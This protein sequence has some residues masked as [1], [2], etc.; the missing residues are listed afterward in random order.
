MI[1][2]FVRHWIGTTSAGNAG[3]AIRGRQRLRSG[4][5][6]GAAV[7]AVASGRES[8]SMLK[9]ALHVNTR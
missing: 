3:V 4:G 7:V 9:F 5:V 6:L 8:S 1:A 2:V